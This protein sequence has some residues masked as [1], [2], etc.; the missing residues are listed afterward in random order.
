MIKRHGLIKLWGNI[1][2]Q[3]EYFQCY[4]PVSSHAI[5]ILQNCEVKERKRPH[6]FKS[7]CDLLQIEPEV[8]T[9]LFS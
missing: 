2:Y 6:C 4:F 5:Q 8:T 1:T 3:Q 7:I 9:T